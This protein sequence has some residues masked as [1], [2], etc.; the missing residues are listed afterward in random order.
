MGP[1]KEEGRGQISQCSLCR[2]RSYLVSFVH[3]FIERGLDGMAYSR[4]RV[5]LWHSSLSEA[6]PMKC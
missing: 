4:W 2:A 1:E 3:L 6:L 5:L